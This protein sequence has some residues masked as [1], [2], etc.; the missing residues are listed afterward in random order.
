VLG[1]PDP[2]GF[3]P[4]LAPVGLFRDP[5]GWLSTN[6]L[7]AAPGDQLERLPDLFEA[8]KPCVGLGGT[9]RGA[10]PVVDGLALA[11]T[12]GS[13]GPTL[14]LAIDPTVW[15]GGAGRAPFAAGVTVGLSITSSGAPRPSVELF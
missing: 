7:G 9:A 13:S 11:I 2:T 15:G 6:V 1:P 3:R 5:G 12:S 14:A 10:W 8:L 4:V